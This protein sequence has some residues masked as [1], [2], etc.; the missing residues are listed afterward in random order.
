MTFYASR[1]TPA[2]SRGQL[3][4]RFSLIVDCWLFFVANAREGLVVARGQRARG[5][6]P[7]VVREELE[8]KAKCSVCSDSVFSEARASV[9]NHTTILPAAAKSR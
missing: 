5:Q 8:L 4:P 7:E 3:T 6:R 9:R 2:R 1:F